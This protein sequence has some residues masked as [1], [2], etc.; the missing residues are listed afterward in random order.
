MADVPV[1]PSPVEFEE[2]QRFRQPA[3][4]VL[5]I[6]LAC[7]GVGTAVLVARDDDSSGAPWQALLVGVLVGLG[8]PAWVLSLEMATTVDADG[9]EVRFGLGFASK[10]FD[11]ADMASARAVTYHPVKE[12]GGWGVRWG[13]GGSRAYNVSGNRGVEVV[14]TSGRRWIIGS[15]R[16]DELAAALVE[17]GVPSYRSDNSDD[18][19]GNP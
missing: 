16:C 2:R 3:L 14:S 4:V 12:F 17:I 15:Q 6:L 5:V 13:R 18:T 19:D 7:L 11:V 10:R 1:I 9:L 8:V